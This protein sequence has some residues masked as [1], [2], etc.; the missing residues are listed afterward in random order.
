[1]K[2]NA[3]LMTDKDLEDGY[4]KGKRVKFDNLIIPP[5]IDNICFDRDLVVIDTL[6]VSGEVSIRFL[7]NTA[8]TCG[9]L[10]IISRPLIK[11][12]WYNWLINSWKRVGGILTVWQNS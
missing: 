1:M 6:I 2:N 4:Y 7:S 10:L 11:T 9:N 3:Y 12:H 5:M 8:V